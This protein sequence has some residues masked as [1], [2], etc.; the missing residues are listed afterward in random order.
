[1]HREIPVCCKLTTS[2]LN[3]ASQVEIGCSDICPALPSKSHRPQREMRLHSHFYCA[4]H[5]RWGYVAIFGGYFFVKLDNVIDC[6]VRKPAEGFNF[7]EEWLLVISRCR[8]ISF[9][10]DLDVGFAGLRA[11]VKR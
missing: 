6:D 5:P 9:V 8:V 10:D 1:M 11:E 7:E 3:S 2:R 4:T